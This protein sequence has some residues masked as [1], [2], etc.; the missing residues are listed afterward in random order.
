MNLAWKT[1]MMG[2]LAATALNAGE[3]NDVILGPWTT[4]GGKSKVEIL[5]SGSTLHG[6]IIWLKEPLYADPKEGPV[7]SP[8]VDSHNPDPQSRGRLIL[9]M[10]IMDGFRSSGVGTWQNGTI[11]DPDNGKTYQCKMKLISPQRL[12]VRGFIGI[13]LIGRTAI[14][15]R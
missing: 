12:E 1:V 9:G 11:Y 7:G 4:E 8:K 3:A 15:T 13:S 2:V 5:Q 14:W 6:R 10:Q